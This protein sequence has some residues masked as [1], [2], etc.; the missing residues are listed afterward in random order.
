MVSTYQKDM[1]SLNS[2]P[3]VTDAASQTKLRWDHAATQVSGCRVGPTLTL[4][5]DGSSEHI[6]ERCAQVEELLHLVTEL[7]E[8]VSKLR[9]IRESERKMDYW[10]HTL[11]S[12]GQA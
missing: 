1:C 10:N 3:A 4:V 11:P 9:S 2:A 12:L 8:E 7:W 6:C 5:L